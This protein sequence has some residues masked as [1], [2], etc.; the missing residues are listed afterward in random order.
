MVK[1]PVTG[2]PALQDEILEELASASQYRRWI[3]DLARPWLGTSP[4]EVGSGSGDHAAEWAAPGVLLTA[5]E[6]DPPR[7]A[8]LRQ[9]FSG[10]PQVR[11]RELVLPITDRQNHSAAVAINVLEHVED[12]LAAVRSM[13]SLVGSGGHVVLFVPAFES[14]MSRF[15]RQVGHYRR[16]RRRALERLL[17]RAGMEPGPVHYVNAPGLFAWFILMR[18]G[19]SQPRDG[20]ALRTFDRIVPVLRWAESRVEPPFGQSLFA[21]GRRP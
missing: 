11:V 4:I 2:D 21:V 14:A 12:D 9:R 20:L 19:G 1:A 6:A 13:A 7:V 5:T 16:Y 8:R 17:G 3:C 10:H 18:L 15:D